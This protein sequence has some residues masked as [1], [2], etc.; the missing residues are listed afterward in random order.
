MRVH[1]RKGL[2][3]SRK[4]MREKESSPPRCSS[5]S[6]CGQRTFKSRTAAIYMPLGMLHG[7][8]S[9]VQPPAKI[10]ILCLLTVP[11]SGM[12]RHDRWIFPSYYTFTLTVY[13]TFIELFLQYVPSRKVI[14]DQNKD[15]CRIDF[16]F[17]QSDPGSDHNIDLMQKFV[18][19]LQGDLTPKTRQ[20][21]A[22][23]QYN[24]HDD[25]PVYMV[26]SRVR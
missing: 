13:D 16:S 8:Q 7:P 24:D 19:F 23:T 21:F 11:T 17:H 10:P 25:N 14:F 3:A 12:T 1:S 5:R 26:G 2:F 22:V 18:P 15:L 4:R 9:S 20:T 6:S